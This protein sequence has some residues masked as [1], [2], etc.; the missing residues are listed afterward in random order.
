M[1]INLSFEAKAIEMNGSYNN[2]V[3]IEVIDAE[4]D[5]VLNNFTIKQIT[6]HFDFVELLNEIG[7]E[8]I[9]EYLS[10]PDAE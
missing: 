7:E 1:K 9:K 2:K 4:G 3:S 5:E 6:E 8:K 10:M